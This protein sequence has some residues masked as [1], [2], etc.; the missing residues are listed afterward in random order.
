MAALS[1]WSYVRVLRW[2]GFSVDEC[3]CKIE[4]KSRHQHSKRHTT[5]TGGHINPN[6]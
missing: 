2:H 4:T 5:G 1:P 6:A 3:R